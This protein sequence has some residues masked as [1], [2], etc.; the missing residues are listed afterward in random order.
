ML[1]ESQCNSDVELPRRNAAIRPEKRRSARSAPILDVDKWQSCEAHFIH[2]GICVPGRI[3]P[4]ISKLDITPVERSI[5]ESFTLSRKK[6]HAD[7]VAVIK[8]EAME[9][10]D[11]IENIVEDNT[12]RLL[13]GEEQPMEDICFQLIL[14]IW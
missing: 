13:N 12:V 5:S 11:T 3:R 14:L 8:A 2:N 10:S 7:K 1:V 6:A 4:T 9:L